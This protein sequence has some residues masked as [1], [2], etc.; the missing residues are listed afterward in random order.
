MPET[1][2]P[3]TSTRSYLPSLPRGMI[4]LCRLLRLDHL[5]H[6][7]IDHIEVA[8]RIDRDSL[9]VI[10]RTVYRNESYASARRSVLADVTVFSRCDVKVALQIGRIMCVLHWLCHRN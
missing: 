5:E 8:L 1:P 7:V 10:E 3:R 9:R 4:H 6:A 2:C